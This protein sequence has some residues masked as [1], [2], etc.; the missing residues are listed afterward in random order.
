MVSLKL[1]TLEF[2]IWGGRPLAITRTLVYSDLVYVRAFSNLKQLQTIV[3]FETSSL[4]SSF[5]IL[6]N[7]SSH[8]CKLLKNYL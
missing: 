5:N 3:V 8:D 4:N 1:N 7:G 6:K 2:K